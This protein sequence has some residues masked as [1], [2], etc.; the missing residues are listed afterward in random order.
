M[1]TTQS[2]AEQHCKPQ[3]ELSQERRQQTSLPEFL[4]KRAQLHPQLTESKMSGPRYG[5]CTKTQLLLA[6]THV[7]LNAW[8]SESLKKRWKRWSRRRLQ[9]L[10]ES[11]MKCW[12][13]WALGQS[14]PYC[15]STTKAGRQVGY[16]TNN[17]E[18]SCHKTH[19]KKGKRQAGSFQLP[20]DQ[21]A[22]L[23]WKASGEDHQQKAHMASWVKLSSG[24]NT[25]RL[26]TIPKHRR[27]TGSLD[28]GH[29]RCLPR[30]EE[31]SGSFLWPVKGLWQSLERGST[32]KASVSR[33]TWQNVQVA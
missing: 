22:Q 33:C 13:T 23:C 28:T 24:F 2:G 17:L 18:G 27:P 8:P 10:M 26:S 6:L 12:N 25:N 7:W 31:G 5:L 16:C 9:D 3:M 11:Q 21:S 30:E 15:T 14:V 20:P 32:A 19:S 4:K 29:R 1:E